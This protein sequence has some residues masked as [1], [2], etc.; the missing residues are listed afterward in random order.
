MSIIKVIAFD[1]DDTLW[2]NEWLYGETKEKVKRLL[3]DNHDPDLVAETID[4]I[5]VANLQF[6]GYGI[7]SFTLSLIEAAITISKGKVDSELI[8]RIIEYGKEMLRTDV[9]LFDGVQETLASL[10]DSYEL[11]L[12][13]K[14]ENKEQMRKVRRSGLAQYFRYIEVVDEKNQQTYC[15]I[16]TKHEIEPSRL[17]M[18]GNSLRSDIEPVLAIGGQAVYIPYTNT[19][20]HETK[21]DMGSIHGK[22]EQV[23]QLSQ[24]PELIQRLDH[25]LRTQ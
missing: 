20:S 1:A 10:H 17:L 8:S 3:S 19:W 9:P 18:V 23:G 2:H 5:E 12:I 24:L 15:E 7:K 13:T 21:I 16:L 6:Y 22:Y 4:D 25:S 14:G 11:M